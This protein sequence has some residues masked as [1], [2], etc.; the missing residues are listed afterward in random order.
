MN[1]N[2]TVTENENEFEQ[3]TLRM[4]LESVTSPS[5][6]PTWGP[7]YFEIRRN[8]W[9]TGH[10][11]LSQN[12]VPPNQPVEPST[13]L[14]SALAL[15]ASTSTSSSQPP[16]RPLTSLERLEISLAKPH[17]E[18]SEEI[19]KKGGLKDIYKCLNDGKKL[20]KGMRLGL[21]I[22]ILR[23]GWLHDGTWPSS[24]VAVAH[25]V[26]RRVPEVGNDPFFDDPVETVPMN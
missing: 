13:T 12:P 23:A 25:G 18:E 22:K 19:W 15:S 17:A 7:A 20:A 2:G 6:P 21:V 16:K 5:E 1:Q 4:D 24:A 11:Y 26:V 8:L 9:R 3:P 10:L 14:T